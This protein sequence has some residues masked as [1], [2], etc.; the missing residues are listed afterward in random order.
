M[1]QDSEPKSP[2]IH[3][4]WQPALVLVWKDTRGQA[5]RALPSAPPEIMEEDED[6]I[7]DE[8]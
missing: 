2:H 5:K 8:F 3:E 4:E 7:H 1:K 6:Y